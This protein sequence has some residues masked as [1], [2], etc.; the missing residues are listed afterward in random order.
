MGF[1]RTATR[2]AA[3]LREALSESEAEIP[4]LLTAT[5]PQ[6]VGAAVRLT[7]IDAVA[8]D[9]W[10]QTWLPNYHGGAGGWNWATERAGYQTDPRRFDLAIWGNDKLCG[11]ALGKPNKGKTILN[12]NLM[13]GNP[14][15]NHPLKGAIRHCVIDAAVRYADILNAMEVRLREPLKGVIPLYEDMGFSLDGLA[16]NPPYCSMRLR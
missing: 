2:Y 11:L 15:S 3:R 5:A 12:V 8:L 10:W 13:E 7:A 9:A 4:T 1:S 16:E 6:C 14:V